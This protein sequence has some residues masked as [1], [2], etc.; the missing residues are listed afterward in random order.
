MVVVI[1]YYL[2]NSEDGDKDD[3][4]DRGKEDLFTVNGCGNFPSQ[5]NG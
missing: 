4:D 1:C 3:E 2:V 5:N